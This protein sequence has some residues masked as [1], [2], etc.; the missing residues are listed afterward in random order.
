MSKRDKK[1][2]E[3][4]TETTFADMNVEGFSWYNPHKKK[5]QTQPI[6]KVSKKEYWAMVRGAFTAMLPM[7]GCIIV[8]GILVFL[9]AFWWLQ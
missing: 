8:G 5:N 3:L 1:R 2:E 4:D 9:I 7:L 6:G